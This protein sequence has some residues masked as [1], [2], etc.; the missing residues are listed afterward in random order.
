[1]NIDIGLVP[2]DSN[3]QFAAYTKALQNVVDLNQSAFTAAIADGQTG[4]SAWSWL[5]YPALAALLGLVAAAVYPRLRE[6]R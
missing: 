5:P 1:M 6:Y 3:Y 2:G 4:L